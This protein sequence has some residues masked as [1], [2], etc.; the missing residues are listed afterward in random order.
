[1]RRVPAELRRGVQERFDTDERRQLAG[2][3]PQTQLLNSVDPGTP[4]AY[5]SQDMFDFEARFPIPDDVP[6]ADVLTLRS[7]FKAS[8]YEPGIWAGRVSPTPLMMLV[9]TRDLVTPTDIALTTYERALQPKRLVMF[10]G[11]HFDAYGAQFETTSAAA[12]DWFVT[13]L[14]SRSEHPS[15]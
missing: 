7:S 12:V 4:A 13:H 9:G 6:P 10:D 2:N 1:L 11:G 15:A 5:H 3:A 8:Q 14:S